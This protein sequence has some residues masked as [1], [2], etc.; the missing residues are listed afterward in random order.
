MNFDFLLKEYDEMF[1]EKRYYDGRFSSLMSLYLSLITFTISAVTIVSNVVNFQSSTLNGVICL[2]DSIS[3][4]LVFVSLYYNRIN[5][6]K[7]C[8]QINSIRN[9]CLTNNCPQFSSCNHMYTNDKYPKY[10]MK[11]TIHSVFMYFVATLDSFFLTI[12]IIA[13]VYDLNLI[14][15]IVIGVALGIC[16]C[17]AQIILANSLFKKRDKHEERISSF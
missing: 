17:F 6:V 15:R 10:L 9:F 7:V 4:F 2:V 1:S 11:N 12:S 3:G 8:R 14:I 16:A 5:Y 13:F